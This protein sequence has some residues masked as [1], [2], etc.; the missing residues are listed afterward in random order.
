MDLLEIVLDSWDRNNTI[1]VNLLRAMPEGGLDAQV[2][3]GSPTVARMFM[4]MHYCRLVFI[5]EDI[6][7]FATE[8]PAEWRS[9]RDPACI[10]QMLNDSAKHVRTAIQS[11]SSPGAG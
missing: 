1:L 2:M 7:E 10:E 8:L 6:P 5:N 4:H 3:E 11:S 9:E